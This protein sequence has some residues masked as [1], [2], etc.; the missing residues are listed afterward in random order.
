MHFTQQHKKMQRQSIINSLVNL[1]A[2]AVDLIVLCR[3]LKPTNLQVGTR[4]LVLNSVIVGLCF[5]VI[6]QPLVTAIFIIDTSRYLDKVDTAVLIFRLLLLILPT[7][8]PL[9]LALICWDK[10]VVVRRLLH[11]SFSVTKRKCI[12][13][14]VGSWIYPAV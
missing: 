7:V 6:F 5:A 1:L 9:S 3:I 2:L 10:F 4:W 8:S 12:A 14:S 11:H 13:L